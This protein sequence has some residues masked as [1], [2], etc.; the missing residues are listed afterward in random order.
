VAALEITSL[1]YFV[2]EMFDRNHTFSLCAQ[3][4]A[5]SLT[6]NDLKTLL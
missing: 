1:K 4:K 3:K 5:H 6:L 2:L